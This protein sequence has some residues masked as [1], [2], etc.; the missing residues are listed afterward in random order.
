V[1]S[2]RAPAEIVCRQ[3]VELVTDYLEGALDRDTA[4]RF[5]EHL[6]ICAKCT[7][8]V[9]QFRLVIAEAGTITAGALPPATRAGLLEAFHGWKGSP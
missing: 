6:A 5:E 9:E 8:Y 1:S 4:T 7:V 3:L 2:A